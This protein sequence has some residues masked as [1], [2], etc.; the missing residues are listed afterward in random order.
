MTDQHTSSQTG[1]ASCSCEHRRHGWRSR[2][3]AIGAA[4]AVV[5]G[6]GGI[7]WAGA[8]NPQVVP[9]TVSITPCRVMDTRPAPN[10]VGPRSTPLAGGS[11]HTIQ[12]TGTN[13]NC[14]IP[15]DAASVLV[16]VTVVGPLA[17]GFLT[18]F[19]S[20]ATRPTAANINYTAGQSPVANLVNAAL[21]ADGQ[22][23]FFASGGPVNLV[24]DIS[25]YTTA[26]RMTASQVAQNRWDKD[27][28][29]PAT[30]DVAGISEAQSVVAFDG[31]S[32]W[33]AGGVASGVRKFDFS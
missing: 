26:A 9:S 1:P 5:A 8:T 19:P 29:K 14:Q 18:A 27:L 20:G 2:W 16:N 23:S 3:A 13:G 28:A 15:N 7:S 31:T 17:N 6:V 25:G 24:A 10:T 32:I 21:G 12:V 11:T 4:I 33:V 22:L 30:I